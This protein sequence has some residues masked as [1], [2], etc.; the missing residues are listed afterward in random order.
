MSN[1]R[2]GLLYIKDLLYSFLFTCWCNLEH[3]CLECVIE[4]LNNVHNKTEQNYNPGIIY[5]CIIK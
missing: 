3:E 1:V 2:F 5:Y 4:R